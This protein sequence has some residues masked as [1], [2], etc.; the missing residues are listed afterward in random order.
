[1]SDIFKVMNLS[2]SKRRNCSNNNV[3]T[4][5]SVEDFSKVDKHRCKIHAIVNGEQTTLN[6]VVYELHTYRVED[7]GSVTQVIMGWGLQGTNHLG[8]SVCLRCE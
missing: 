7:D 2:W 5:I 6:A 8:I 4:D 1:M 3:I